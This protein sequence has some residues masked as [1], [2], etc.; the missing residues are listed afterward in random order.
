MDKKTVDNDNVSKLEEIE[1]LTN[2]LTELIDTS[3]DRLSKYCEFLRNEVDICT[4]SQ[5]ML[6]NNYR[7][8][9]FDDISSYQDRCIEY[10]RD[11]Q[12]VGLRESINEIKTKYSFLKSKI[13]D[14]NLV[15]DDEL[16]ALEFSLNHK[17]QK[18]NDLIFCEK[19][20]V[21]QDSDLELKPTHIGQLGYENNIPEKFQLKNLEKIKPLKVCFVRKTGTNRTINKVCC[22]EAFENSIAIVYTSASKTLFGLYCLT[23]NLSLYNSNGIHLKEIT[24]ESESIGALFLASTLNRIVIATEILNKP[25]RLQAYDENLK[26]KAQVNIDHCI[27]S[28][29]SQ[30]T[31][32]YL[33]T[34]KLLFLHI[35][36]ENLQEIFTL[37]QNLNPNT[38]F[39]V[40]LDSKLSLIENFLI[41][42]DKKFVRINKN[43]Y[44]LRTIEIEEKQF[45]YFQALTVLKYLF[46][47]YNERLFMIYDFNGICNEKY[48][49]KN[50]ANISSVFITK[51]NKLVVLDCNANSFYIYL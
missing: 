25:S 24:F 6:L 27:K 39:Y 13:N 44:A 37:G 35:Y 48:Y 20:L 41:T 33:F 40:R 47:D 7:D 34:T 30:N 26:L 16:N 51:K 32:I 46:V 36:N 10:R 1:T 4:E 2:H 18:L 5:I 3:N 17:K 19:K 14:K 50:V 8:Q 31:K 42:Y 11:E 23:I 29:Y 45:D 9:M 12:I 22:C 15:L 28:I 38:A 43:G 49:I 21:F